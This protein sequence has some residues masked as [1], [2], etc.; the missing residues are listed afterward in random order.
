MNQLQLFLP[1]AAGVEDLLAAEVKRITGAQGKAWRAGVQVP[2]SWRDALQ[3]NLHSR[4]AQRV[5]IELQHNSY[6]S[7]QDLYNAAA[8]VAWEIWFT[9]KQTFNVEITAQ[10][11]PLT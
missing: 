1:C 8:G 3:L 10:H 7:E 2:G 9:P 11:S 4:L 5:L 6:R